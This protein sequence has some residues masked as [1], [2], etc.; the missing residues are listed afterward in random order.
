MTDAVVVEG[1]WK[2]YHQRPQLGIKELL[3]RRKALGSSR[4]SREWALQDISFKVPRGC[5]FGIMGHNGTGKST[6]LG[7]L[8]GTM[9]P[10]RG[11]VRL[12]GRVASLLDIG[13]GFHPELTGRE[14]IFLWGAILGMTLREMRHRLDEV[15]AFSELSG[16]IDNP[17]RT[18]SSG[19]ITRLGFSV[20]AHV[21]ADVLLIDEVLAVG[22]ARFQEKCLGKMRSFKSG[23]GTIV[24]VSH[25]MAS[26]KSICDAGMCLN[27]GRIVAQGGIDEVID[28]YLEVLGQSTAATEA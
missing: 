9:V 14:N 12:A 26:L 15:I 7:L 28:R 25:D 16:A 3:V 19:M 18:Y 4:F 22:D 20:I 21:P 10:D 2:S 24:L 8:L 23:G 17:L 11:T 6:L 1:L 5:A 27:E 13:A